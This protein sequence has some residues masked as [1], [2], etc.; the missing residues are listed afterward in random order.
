MTVREYFKTHRWIQGH[1]FNYDKDCPGACLKGAI[2]EISNYNV[3]DS[4]PKLQKIS[5]HLGIH[6]SNLH[7]WNDA[8]GRTLD[9][10][11]EVT[12]ACGL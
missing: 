1:L 11:L 6:P 10:V 2:Y 12:D 7:F 4:F 9:E 5:N 8:N 3:V